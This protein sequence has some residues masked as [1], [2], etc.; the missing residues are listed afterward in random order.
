MDLQVRAEQSLSAR[1]LVF[2]DRG[3]PACPAFFRLAG[4]NPN[5]FLAECFHYRYA[6]VFL[7][8]PLEFERNGT[9][10]DNDAATA[11]Y[12]SAWHARD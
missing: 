7:L 4:V 10:M 6:G 1:D 2:L 9:R 5:D 8:D 11:P 12:L 3:V